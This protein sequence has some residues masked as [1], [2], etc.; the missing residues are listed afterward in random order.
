ME[1]ELDRC[2][3]VA[4]AAP[5]GQGA[6]TGRGRSTRLVGQVERKLATGWCRLVGPLGVAGLFGQSDEGQVQSVAFFARAQQ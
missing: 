2:G 3:S 5:F 4:A 6:Y 1:L